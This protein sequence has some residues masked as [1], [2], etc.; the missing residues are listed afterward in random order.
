M[1]EYKWVRLKKET[2]TR[3]NGFTSKTESYDTSINR[4]MDKTTV[5]AVSGQTL[6]TSSTQ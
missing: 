1:T 3:L 6:N 5:C 2:W 4:I